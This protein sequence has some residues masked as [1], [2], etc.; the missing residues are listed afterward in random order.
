MEQLGCHHPAF[1]GALRILK[2][3][4]VLLSNHFHA[5]RFREQRCAP[6]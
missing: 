5:L 3:W 1:S 2:S 6:V 4:A